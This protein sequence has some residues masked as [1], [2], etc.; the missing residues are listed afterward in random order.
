MRTQEKQPVKEIGMS[1]RQMIRCATIL[2]FSFCLSTSV[3]A[4]ILGSDTAANYTT[5]TNG[6]NAGTGFEPWELTT[7]QQWAGHFLG[8]STDGGTGIDIDTD[9][10]AFGMYANPPESNSYANAVRYFTGGALTIG[11]TFTIELGVNY[12]NGNKGLDLY[13]GSGETIFNLNFGDN[14]GGMKIEYGSPTQT[15]FPGWDNSGNGYNYVLTFTKGVGNNTEFQ[16]VR[17][18]ASTVTLDMALSAAPAGFHLYSGAT[19]SGPANNFYAN[20]LSITET[21]ILSLS[22][23]EG[24]V[25]NHTNQLIVSRTGPTNSALV[26][27]LNSGDPS[28]LTVTPTVTIGIGAISAVAEV[29]G[30]SR[31]GVYVTASAAGLDDVSTDVTVYNVA[32][33]SSAYYTA[34]TW[35]NQSNGGVGW[36]AWSL[37]N[38]SGAE[39]G[40]TNFAG[41]FL[42]DSTAD[43]G[44]D[45]NGH[46]GQAFGLYAS[47]EGT[48][49][50][51]LST[52]SR[53]FGPMIPGQQLSVAL[54]VNY[55]NGSKGLV[56]K[57]GETR[58]FEVA[59]LNNDYAFA[60]WGDGDTEFTSLGWSYQ[61]D[62]AIL[63]QLS[64]V[65]TDLYNVII[66]R[67]G[68]FT[69]YT[70]LHG[71]HLGGLAPD[72]A[73]FYVY[74]TEAGGAN[75]LFFN[76]MSINSFD[77]F[78]MEGVANVGIGKT[79]TVFIARSG[80]TGTA[81]TVYLTSTQPSIL[82]VPAS[83]QIEAGETLASFEISGLSAG[84]AFVCGEAM[85]YIGGPFA[86]DVSDLPAEGDDAGN[87]I[88]GRLLA[89]TFTNGANAG[90][91][92]G[93][94]LFSALANGANIQLRSF[95]VTNAFFDSANERSF[96]F[97]GGTDGS[98]ATAYRTLD[99]PLAAGD[100]I[101]V[102]LGVSWSGGNRG[103]DLQDASGN[104]LFNF[105]LS[106]EN[107]NAI[108]F[109]TNDTVNLGWGY[110]N[111]SAI[112]V[113]AE[114]LA[115]NQLRVTLTRNDGQTTN[116]V[117][118]DLTAHI[119][120]I[121]FYNGGHDAGDV[122]QILYA[123]DLL[124][125]RSGQTEGIPDSWWERYGIAI[126]Q[127]VAT[128]NPDSDTSNNFEEYVADTNP[129]DA[130]SCFPY[131]IA[132][133]TG[134]ETLCMQAV[135]TTNS[136]IYDVWWST[137]LISGPWTAA[138][139]NV[140]GQA[141]GSAVD[142]CVSST[143]HV[144]RFYR[145]GI[146]VP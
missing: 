57:N 43:G 78:T 90:G 79:S 128:N 50:G 103:L 145:T 38:N 77:L 56:I 73:H 5:W 130:G 48:G 83:V 3:R 92:F 62:T 55:R 23:Q 69:D 32:Y 29:A 95:D 80:D 111:N 27:N 115:G 97:C 52:A 139:L 68:S 15:N 114:Q 37:T 91:G 133:T 138:G 13:N 93:P 143:N 129:T 135:P 51:P 28:I 122:R 18:H 7:W 127:R 70:E 21:T 100:R 137:N 12:W 123:N 134:R 106:Y 118:S 59:V 34:G 98:Y 131:D 121:N 132:V 88:P 47:Q 120:R 110:D 64:C 107:I 6:S 31:G 40:F 75:N 67:A 146:R 11:Q 125:T 126:G 99:T 35:T 104:K 85:D 65:G 58:L 105:N 19:E 49:G 36:G 33:D 45:V 41:A 124:I 1:I 74:N 82:T 87:Y 89:P 17:N 86:A 136:R 112:L 116:V 39:A 81:L 113:Q 141:N 20:N 16:M 108:S 8:S 84:L 9:G 140:P 72:T 144:L 119:G 71:I 61:A 22:S 10:K 63:I 109:G 25:V 66:S 42:G 53:T 24:M 60:N 4:A 54:G 44:G 26:V 76:E 102:L 94:W 2:M 46:D 14:S 101:E 142:L 96:A 30:I 117:S